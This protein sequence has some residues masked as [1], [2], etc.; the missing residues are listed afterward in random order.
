MKFKLN[1]ARN[2]N[3]FL[4]LARNCHNLIILYLS[5][6]HII[7]FFRL[8]SLLASLYLLYLQLFRVHTDL[9]EL[10]QDTCRARPRVEKYLQTP[11]ITMQ[12][13]TSCGLQLR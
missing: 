1:Q 8:A 5:M 4:K 11:E 12:F 10:N 9:A 13:E 3:T 2:S 6:E 7:T